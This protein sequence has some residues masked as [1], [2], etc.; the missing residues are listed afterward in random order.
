MIGSADRRN[1]CTL[2]IDANHDG[3]VDGVFFE[4]ERCDGDALAAKAVLTVS[5]AAR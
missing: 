4:I 2:F 5:D 1:D 3:H